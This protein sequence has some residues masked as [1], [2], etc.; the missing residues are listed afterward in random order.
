MNRLEP[1]I[2]HL[3]LVTYN[4]AASFLTRH[5]SGVQV[6]LSQALQMMKQAPRPGLLIEQISAL[7]ILAIL[8][9]LTL[10]FFLQTPY[11]GFKMASGQVLETFA[12]SALQPG[13]ALVQVGPVPIS[14]F[15]ADLRQTLFNGVRP[16]EVVPILVRRNGQILSTPYVFPGITRNELVDRLTSQWWLAL[17][18]WFFGEL[19]LLLVRPKDVS[20]SLL[21]AF[22]FVTAVWLAASI[23]SGWHTWYSAIV[24][25][26]S[27]WLSVPVYWHFHSVFPKP[28]QR[29]PAL[30]GWM[31]Y[32]V[33]VLLAGAEWLRLL[34]TQA[35]TAGFLLAFIG[36]LVLL[37]T[38]LVAQP[39]QRRDLMLI[40]TVG[41]MAL[42]LPILLGVVQ[43][44][45]LPLYAAAAGLLALPLLP[46]AYFYAA[47]RRQLGALELRANRLIT[48]YL[49]FLLL[50]ATFA[51]L[52][53]LAEAMP[54]FPG[55]IIFTG[56]AAV[57]LT[58]SLVLVGF[59][60]FQRFVERRLLGMPLPPTRLLE[61][62]AA[63]ITVSLDTSTLVRLLQD[64]ILPSLLI[65]QSALLRFD[66][67]DPTVLYA[68]GLGTA[69]FPTA[70]NIPAL[71]A[72]AG[73][74]RTPE[75]EAAQP[76]PWV[77][78]ALPLTLGD[79]PIGLWLFGR[80]DPDDVYAQSEIAT[81]Q[82][83]AHQTAIALT[84]IL[85]AERLH[86]LY[87]ADI[88]RAETERATLARGLHDQL[89]NQLATLKLS[90]GERIAPPEFLRRYEALIAGLR[91]IISELRPPMLNYGL[92]PALNALVDE[93]AERPADGPTVVLD[94]PDSDTRYD[95]QLEQH[96]YRIVQQAVEN[97]LRHAQARAITIRGRLEPERIDL[98]VADDG[99]GFAAGDG[100]D[101][102]GLLS[103]RHF[104]LAGMF[105]RAA[106][107]SA[108]MR[109]DSV[110]GQ[111]T[112]VHILW[113]RNSG[114]GPSA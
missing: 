100:V 33:G 55:D 36:S 79:Q 66:N 17:V 89:L 19:T 37:I 85:Q 73:R 78:L 10:A 40:V 107:V 64:R 29:L 14:N 82:S 24:L 76:C 97:A 63:Q 102:A 42:G 106:L 94:L 12:P 99:V 113:S 71:L 23:V 72:R 47:Y 88:D 48:L 21:A 28:L 26:A 34:P 93:L 16:G 86:A 111:G 110:P 52:L 56:F 62:Y 70:E 61:T 84:N 39:A 109:I 112:Q 49:F 38:H 27:V 69:Q 5:R 13:D 80:R 105:E 91:Q 30:V 83:L 41:G 4:C 95:L 32:G 77:R 15:R 8:V 96:L 44:A 45:G 87:Q 108:Q 20:W 101:L 68:T 65:R 58:A 46:G 60:P 51:I 104:G 92:C 22:N 25:R 2:W 43:A 9:M 90:L 114:D 57:A 74:Y 98:T 50:G 103:Q 11:A 31:L 18:F 81:L 6:D 3:P 67:P 35:Y 7:L 53:P 59:A 54:D 75:D 1:S